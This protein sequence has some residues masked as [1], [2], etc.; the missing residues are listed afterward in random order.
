MMRCVAIS[1]GN[2][3]EDQDD[4]EEF[5][6]QRFYPCFQE[7][8]AVDQDDCKEFVSSGS[9]LA[10]KNTTGMHSSLLQISRYDGKCIFEIS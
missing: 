8:D 3:T 4:C 7:Y 2:D 5:C 9:I 6:G 1:S 10:S